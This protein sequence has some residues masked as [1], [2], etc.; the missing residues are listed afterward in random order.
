MDTLQALG[1]GTIDLVCVNLY[2]FASAAA[3]GQA[4]DKAVEEID[5]GGPCMIRAAG[6]N[7]RSVLV[8]PETAAYEE[9]RAEFVRHDGSVTLDFRRRMAVRA[10]SLTAAYDAMIADYLGRGPG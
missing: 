3:S 6:K 5:I 1:L 10:F 9:F 8:L 2:D 7:C 4:P